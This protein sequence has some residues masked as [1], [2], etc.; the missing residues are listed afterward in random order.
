M[1][2]VVAG[3]RADGQ[4]RALAVL[5]ERGQPVLP[6]QFDLAQLIE[7][8]DQEGLDVELLDVDEGR[9]AGEVVGALL[10]QVERINLVLA[11]KRAA[12]APLDALGRDAVVYAQALEDL[13]RPLRVADAAR[14][15]ALDADR[16]VTSSTTAG[17]PR[18]ASAHASVRPVMPAPTM[19]TGCRTIAPDFSS[20]GSTNGY[21]GSW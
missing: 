15:R 14:R 21:S 2:L 10:A 11:G 13:Q 9:L 20:G 16:V 18:C 1:Q 7:P 3:G 5:V 6:A 12:N 8:V 17:M 4:R 19:T